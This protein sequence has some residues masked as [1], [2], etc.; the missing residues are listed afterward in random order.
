MATGLGGLTVARV[1]WVQNTTTATEYGMYVSEAGR[2]SDLDVDHLI[3]LKRAHKADGWR[4]GNP[5]RRRS[6]GICSKYN[7]FASGG[8]T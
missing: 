3:P 8:G 1:A 2:V 6:C 4:D 7:F 5:Y